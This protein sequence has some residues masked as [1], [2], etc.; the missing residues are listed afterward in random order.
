M[1]DADIVAS[2]RQTRKLLVVL[3]SIG[4]PIKNFYLD[5]ELTHLIPKG[6][7]SKI[8]NVAATIHHMLTVIEKSQRYRVAIG[9]TIKKVPNE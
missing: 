5:P 7:P 9:A 8:V 3:D 6:L 2:V 4:F 1:N